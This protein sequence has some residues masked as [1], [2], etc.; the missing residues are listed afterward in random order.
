MSMSVCVSVCDDI[1]AEPQARYLPFLC[2]LPMAV[3]RS[4]SGVIA[5]CY[6]LPVLWM[7]SCFFYNKPYSGMNFAMKD[8]FRI[9]LLIYRKVGH[10]SIS[11]Y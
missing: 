2:M 6:V 11:Y 9:N 1:S 3:A 10:N 5:T 8:R 4:S 7:T